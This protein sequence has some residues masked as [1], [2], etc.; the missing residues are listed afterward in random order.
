[1]KMS[2]RSR[3]GIETPNGSI[4]SV[5]CHWDGY[6]SYTGACLFSHYQD[7]G[8]VRELI[9][10]GDMSSIGPN[11]H[12]IGPHSYDNKEKDVVVFYSRDKG[13]VECETTISDNR[14]DFM[15]LACDSWGEFVYLFSNGEWLYSELTDENI[16]NTKFY[17]LEKGL[18]K[19]EYA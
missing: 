2:T 15:Q 3:I 14:E 17:S 10:L 8:K 11:I 16:E 4:Y 1:M 6:L 12:P 7:E 5:S 13:Y 9:E 18:A 19:N